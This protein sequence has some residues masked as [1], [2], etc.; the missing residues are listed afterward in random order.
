MLM[1]NIITKVF[2]RVLRYT[3]PGDA[4]ARHKGVKVGSGCRIISKDFGSEPFLIEI[5]DKVTISAN[6][7]LL[8]HDGATWLLNDERGRAFKYGK[9]VI[10]SECFIGIGSIIMPGVT[11]G[12]RVIVGAGS[13]VTKSIPS[14]EIWAGN[15]ARKIGTF[16][17]FARNQFSREADMRGASFDERVRSI[18]G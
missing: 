10:G 12:D 7:F 11:I 8:T 16:E 6:V 17:Q 14:G 18:L 15:P 2:D 1:R 4:Y 5:G 3:M 13:V 9:V